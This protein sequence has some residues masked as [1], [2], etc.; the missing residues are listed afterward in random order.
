M[1]LSNSKLLNLF[2][3]LVAIFTLF[4]GLIPSLP[5]PDTT[6]VSAIV[7]F[8]VLALTAWRQAFSQIINNAALWPTIIIAAIAT[9]GGLND[10]FDVFSISDIAGQWIRFSI[11]A[12]TAVLNLL[13]TTFWPIKDKKI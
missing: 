4:Q 12:L 10:L 9:I 8:L 3:M 5:I 11:T 7:M 6:V 1:A 2:T 13:S